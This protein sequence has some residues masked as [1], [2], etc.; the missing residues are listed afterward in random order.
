MKIVIDNRHMDYSGGGEHVRMMISLLS[1]RADLYVTK[2]PEFY[3]KNDFSISRI[4]T[5][6]KQFRYNFIP[7]LFV[8]IDFRGYTKPIGRANAQLVFYGLNKKTSGYDFAICIN[9][10]VARSVQN[11]FSDTKPVVIPPFFDPTTYSVSAKQKRLVN[12]GNFFRE[13]DGHSKNQHLLIDWFLDSGL[14]ESG[15]KFD[16]FGFKNNNEYFKELETKIARSPSI[17]LHPNSHRGDIVIALSQSRFL[18]H[19]MGYGRIKPEQTEHFGL[20]AVESLLSGCRPIVHR[21]GGCHEIDGTLSYTD[22][23]EI[24]SLIQSDE[25]SAHKLRELGRNYSYEKS[26]L[27]TEKFLQEVNALLEKKG[28]P[29]LFSDRINLLGYMLR[30]K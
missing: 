4:D 1:N 12:I 28:A 3:G 19:A 30:K 5:P 10:F 15:W 17:R 26:L 13:A 8:Y 20:V 23:A 9:D 16:F 7:D 22:L 27:A 24:T 29:N 14:V 25:L 11:N 21:S 2:Q 6:P 18:V